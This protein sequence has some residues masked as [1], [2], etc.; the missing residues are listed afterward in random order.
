VKI[1]GF[2]IELGEIEAV[3]AGQ[4]GVQDAAVIATE[5]TAG[6]KRLAAHVV[7]AASADLD[8]RALRAALRAQLPTY[9][10]P[11]QIRIV[12]DLPRHPSGKVDRM[13]LAHSTTTSAVD[14]GS[15]LPPAP[16]CPDSTESVIAKIW[17]DVLGERT[18]PAFD[19]NFFDAGGDSLS[20]LS[21]QTMLN[22]RFGIELNVVDLFVN[23]TIAQLER[24]IA[25]LTRTTHIGVSDR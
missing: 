3:L 2:R 18:A 9:M 12:A 20:L 21:M 16:P 13:A 25:G 22:E 14:A 5:D 7:A 6:D 24:L 10:V 17:C 4:P 11:H 1:N 8:E 19:I 15:S 23:T